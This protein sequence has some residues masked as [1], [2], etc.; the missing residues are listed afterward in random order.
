MKQALFI[1]LFVIQAITVAAQ[2]KTPKWVNKA[3]KAIFSIEINTKDGL[4]KTGVGFFINEKGEAVAAYSLFR[5]A[6][7]A[8]VKTADGQIFPVTTILGA[9]DMYDVIRFRV[10]IS[11][12]NVFLEQAVKMP[13]TG[14]IVYIPPSAESKKL[15]QG[16]VIEI[17]KIKSDYG[18]YKIDVPLHVSQEGYPLLDEDGD[19]FAFTQQ[20]AS[21]KGKTF[22]ISIAYIKSLQ[23]TTADLLKRTYSE[24]GISKALPSN[25]DDARISTLLNASQQDAPTYLK[26]LTDF[27]AAFPNDAEGYVNRATHYAYKRKELA[28]SEAEQLKMLDLATEDL[29]KAAKINK[30]KDEDWFNRAKL[31]FGV[32]AGDSALSYKDWNIATAEDYI[33]KA[34]K[35]N[36]MPEYRQLEGDIAYHKGDYRTAYNSYSIVNQSHIASG[37][38]FFI[39]AKCLQQIPGSNPFDIIALIDSA[40]DKSPETEATEY[41]LEN[42][43]LKTQAGLY[44]NVVKD[45]DKYF[46]LTNGNVNNAFYYFREQAKYRSGDYE[47]ALKDI[48]KAIQE[49]SGNNCVYY[50]EKSSVCLRLQ[51]LQGAQEAAEKAIELQ[52]DFAAAYRLLGI[53]LIRQDKKPDGCLHLNKAKELGDTVVERLITEHCK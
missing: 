23:I 11:K 20:D 6:Q 31:I 43:D 48:E 47:G 18:Y 3:E 22:G 10:G 39:T 25:I 17:T 12:K 35:E 27:I 21:G 13:S 51:N 50:A 4:S 2:T 53:A 33:R 45:Y 34:I 30:K 9:D 42:I 15:S 19:V 5:N 38:S 32:V 8:T 49:T 26:T 36:N 40:V 52:P 16:A 46:L 7:T 24:T 41:L 14:D 1:L 29:N 28:Q 37:L 44:E